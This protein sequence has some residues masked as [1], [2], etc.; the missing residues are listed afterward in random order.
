MAKQSS[1]QQ[2]SA[3]V[4]GVCN[5]NSAEV[6]YRKKAAYFGV[7]V[8]LVLFIVLFAFDIN[9]YARLILFIPLLIAAVGYL[10]TKNKFCVAY[11][12]TG[13]QNAT[14]DSPTAEAV[15]DKDAAMKDKI[16]A[17]SMN[18]QAM[19]IAAALTALALLV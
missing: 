7:A 9:R 6:A 8:S 18:I 2:D 17:R 14:E 11:G 4:P 19:I 15:T 3:Y 13:K 12:A 1:T 16:K 5:I 10:Q